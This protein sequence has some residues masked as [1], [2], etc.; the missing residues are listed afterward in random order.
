MVSMLIARLASEAAEGASHAI[1]PAALIAA[2]IAAAFFLVL[3]IVTWSYR[4]V[5]NRHADKTAGHDSHAGH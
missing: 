3:A 4:D 2:G 5:A 1:T